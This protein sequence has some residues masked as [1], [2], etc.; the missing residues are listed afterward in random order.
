MFANRWVDSIDFGILFI[1]LDLFDEFNAIK[2]F[3]QFKILQKSSV[4]FWRTIQ[5]WTLCCVMLQ[6]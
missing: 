4:K 2:I 1:N 5:S 3:A 6:K